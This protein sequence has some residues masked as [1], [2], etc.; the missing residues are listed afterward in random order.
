MIETRGYYEDQ[1]N[2]GFQ[3][4][5]CGM[6]KTDG[7]TASYATEVEICVTSELFNIDVFVRKPESGNN[8]W[9]KYTFKNGVAIF[10]CDHSRGY[11][12]IHNE[13]DHYQ[14]VYC[15]TRPCKCYGGSNQDGT[16]NPRA[17]ILLSLLSLL[18]LHPPLTL[19]SFFLTPPLIL[20]HCCPSRVFP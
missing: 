19:L 8:E 16:S 9:N 5:I 3:R 15:P 14:L 6:R 2:Q 17:F 4:H 11:I 10:E 18:L 13:D 12:T 1:I 7:H 20:H